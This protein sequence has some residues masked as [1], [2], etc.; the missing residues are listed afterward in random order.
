MAAFELDGAP[1]R[2]PL[3]TTEQPSGIQPR[4]VADRHPARVVRN[5]ADRERPGEGR[6]HVNVALL[7][8]GDVVKKIPLV[9]LPSNPNSPHHLAGSGIH[10]Q[11]EYIIEPRSHQRARPKGH[12]P[13][14]GPGDDN[15][16]IRR[17]RHAG[18]CAAGRSFQP[19]NPPNHAIG[20]QPT[21]DQP[22]PIDAH[23]T[24]LEPS[25]KIPAGER[26]SAIGCGLHVETRFLF[27]AER[28][29]EG[30]GPRVHDDCIKRRVDGLAVRRR[31]VLA[32]T[33]DAT[34]DGKRHGNAAIQARTS[35]LPVG[36]T[37]S[38]PMGGMR[39][40]VVAVS[41]SKR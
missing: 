29:H 17:D 6:G 16:P 11:H 28:E 37:T 1:D 12:R 18:V 22:G 31:V 41:L 36:S 3:P 9:V 4:E 7:V 20:V 8:E 39:M 30:T 25:A 10:D 34:S 32:G 24:H 40:P 27:A 14:E 2:D 26:C 15:V 33:S 19:A 35:S 23:R 13:G 21:D 5:T 38:R